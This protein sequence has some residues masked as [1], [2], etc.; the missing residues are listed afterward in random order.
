MRDAGRISSRLLLLA[1]LSLQGC[2]LVAGHIRPAWDQSWSRLQYVASAP[3]QPFRRPETLRVIARDAN[4]EVL[5]GTTVTVTDQL[6]HRVVA[7]TDSTGSASFDFTPGAVVVRTEMPGYATHH[8]SVN[9]Q[10]GQTCVLDVFSAFTINEI[11]SC[12]AGG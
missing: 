9:L 5:P 1:S 6:G 2:V 10:A 11:P 4:G 7:I 12:C 3:A 8:C